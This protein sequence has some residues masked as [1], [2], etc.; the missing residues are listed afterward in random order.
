MNRIQRSE[1]TTS[2]EETESFAL[3]CGNYKS[4]PLPNLGR[5]TI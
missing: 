3:H 2:N 1:S 5:K 4:L